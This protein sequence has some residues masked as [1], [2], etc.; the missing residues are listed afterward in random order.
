[1]PLND[2]AR[3]LR[4]PG[5]ALAVA[6]LLLAGCASNGSGQHDTGSRAET[7]TTAPSRPDRTASLAPLP[8]AIP[9]ALTPYYQ[10]KLSWQG[11]QPQ[12]FECATMRVPLDYGHPSAGDIRLAVSRKKATGPGERLGSLLV[13]PGGPGGSAIDYLADAAVRYPAPVRA[14]YDMVAV[15]PR[16][17]ARSAPVTCLTDAE[18]DAYTQTDITPDSPTEED[19]VVTADQRFSA[20]CRRRSAKLL[21]HV[22]TVESARDMDVLRALLGDAK[23]TYV[24]KSYGTFLGATYAGLFPSRVGRMVLDGAMDPTLTAL[25]TGRQQ[26]AGF[27]T[28][29]QAFAKDCVA[30]S[31]CP[32][33]TTTEAAGAYIDH[34]LKNLD[35]HPLPAG[36]RRLVEALGTTGLTEAMYSK[37]M[38]PLLR[39]A[40]TAANSGD[41]TPLLALS[42]QYYERGPNGT[43]ANLMYANTAVNCL[44]L[45]AATNGPAAVE[46][47]LPSFR[48]ASP[49]F[50]TGF[51]WMS[52][53]CA[54]WPVK[55]TGRPE[56]IEAKGAA[57][58]VVVGTTRDPATPYP[59]A[60]SLAAQLSS[61]HLITYDGDGHTAYVTGSDCVDTAVNVYLLTGRPPHPDL[62]CT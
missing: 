52:L 49:H 57:P 15:D 47:A 14:Q 37:E 26:A 62:R 51:A 27:E 21:P 59:W 5:I 7:G 39:A 20:G 41:G 36:N 24:G 1:M 42:D 61:G 12:G 32:M 58:I 40:L 6:G 8:A 38:W 31:D 17:V 3:P 50:G 60:R 13:N 18:M 44:D 33:G 46:A 53:S 45:P 11:C 43:Y 34:F 19:A 56:R 16:G 29:F 30:H 55:P 23:L 54:S 2:T 35:A 25:E 4:T 48:K 22:S 10:Q 28:A 9:S